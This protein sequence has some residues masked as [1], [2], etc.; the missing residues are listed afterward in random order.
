[1]INQVEFLLP[2]LLGGAS[3]LAVMVMVAFEIFEQNTS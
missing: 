3:A 2:H 1:M